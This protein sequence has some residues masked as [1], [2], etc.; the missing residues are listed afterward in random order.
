VTFRLRNPVRDER[1]R[2]AYARELWER[3]TPAAGTTVE[4]YL[5][6]RGIEI[7]VPST[8][9]FLPEAKHPTGAHLPVM[10]AGVQD[11]SGTIVAVHRTFLKENGIGKADIEPQK[12]MLGPVAGAAVRFGGVGDEIAVAEGIESA[13]SVFQAVGTPTWA[14]LSAPGLAALELPG[15]V[16]HV[17]V[18]ADGDDVGNA[19]AEYAAHRW[20]REG[21]HVRI[22]H[23]P[24]GVDANDLLRMEVA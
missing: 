20:W 12:M 22:C 23:P 10:L 19:A 3:S 4:K 5:R 7:A 13:L 14:A 6:D 11:M 8:I 24:R 17:T 15:M 18:V 16:A 21:R 1:T 9:R 2:A